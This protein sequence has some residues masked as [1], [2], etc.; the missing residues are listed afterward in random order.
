MRTKCLGICLQSM[1]SGA[2]WHRLL[3]PASAGGRLAA[4]A[5][6]TP[7]QLRTT[8]PY[9][10][11]TPHPASR[12]R[13]NEATQRSRQSSASV[14][15]TD[16]TPA[17]QPMAAGSS[18]AEHKSLS[19][20]QQ[21]PVSA[22]GY[23]PS[24][25]HLAPRR[26]LAEAVRSPTGAL[27][28]HSAAQ[29][30]P[31]HVAT[32]PEATA[33][34]RL[35][36]KL[37][38]SINLQQPSTTTAAERH[39]STA[40]AATTSPEATKRADLEPKP[41]SRVQ[42][43]TKAIS[44]ERLDGG[45]HSAPA[46]TSAAAHARRSTREPRALSQTAPAGSGAARRT[47]SPR[48]G[49]TSHIS[50]SNNALSPKLRQNGGSMEIGSP[51]QCFKKGFGGGYYQKIEPAKLEDFLAD[52]NAP[53]KKLIDQPLFYGDGAVPPGKIRATLSQCMQRGFGVGSMQLA[54]RILKER[55][56]ARSK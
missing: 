43:R 5:P 45:P 4:V 24:S 30:H 55:N 23:S 1:D 54:K 37:S 38:S 41:H 11:K 34:A 32:S 13:A 3:V 35:E 48:K 53:Y 27:T 42:Q 36:R 22:R 29:V 17:R 28:K 18:A 12:L 50:C 31:L 56:H 21:P 33:R 44:S 16:A 26:T 14:T 51:S 46:P 10:T 2:D 39:N 15:T 7:S 49:K 40:K 25:P 47:T 20:G 8:A 52:F 6:K 9:L 19:S